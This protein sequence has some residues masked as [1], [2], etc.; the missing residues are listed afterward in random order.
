MKELEITER[1]SDG[2]TILEIKGEVDIYS[3]EALKDRL[4]G[5]AGCQNLLLNIAG[6]DYIDSFGLSLLISYRK[7]MG[8]EGR[9]LG[10][11]CPQSY[12]KRILNLTKLY[13]FLAVYD[14]EDAAIE[15]FL[16]GD[17]QI[18]LQMEPKV[19]SLSDERRA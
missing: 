17:G 19:S 4:G 2:V 6:I 12:V 15:S 8:K 14:D 5:L 18:K 11:C 9:K 16:K 1:E 10:L 3:G 7:K 13:D